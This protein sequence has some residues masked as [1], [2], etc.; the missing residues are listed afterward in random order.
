MSLISGMMTCSSF[1]VTAFPIWP[2]LGV[3]SYSVG[4]G[5]IGS[6]KKIYLFHE[7]SIDS[8]VW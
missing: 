2:L 3:P 6:K 4:G 7:K 1:Y 5:V 8:F